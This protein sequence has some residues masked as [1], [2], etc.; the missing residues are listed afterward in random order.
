LK[1]IAEEFTPGT[2]LFEVGIMEVSSD[3]DYFVVVD[4]NRIVYLGTLNG[5]TWWKV[6]TFTLPIIIPKFYTWIELQ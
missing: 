5:D 3:P 1:G 2:K 4:E 6:T